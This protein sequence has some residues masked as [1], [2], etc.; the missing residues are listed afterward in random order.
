[1]N[2]RIKLGV[3]AAS[4]AALALSACGSSSLSG[5]PEGGTAPSV[6]VSQNVDLASKLPE[7]IKS[8]GV[9]KIGTDP[10]YAPSEFLAADGKTVEGF[11]V[12]LFNQVAAKFGVKTEWEPSKFGSIIT[13]VNGKKYDMGISS[14]TINPDRLKEVD[15]VSYFNA[16]TQWATQQGNPKG[17]DPNNACGKN[18]AVQTGTVQENPD[19]STR[20]KKCGSNK[21]NVLSYDSQAQ[22]TSAVVTGK[23]DAMLADSPV[24]AYAVK[25]SGGKLEAL[26]DI[27]EAA[28][29]GYVL[30]KGETEFAQAIVEALKQLEQEG[31]YKAALE[32]WGV[33]QGAISDFAVNP[34]S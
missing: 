6:S 18:I 2:V 34:A 28:P 5:E 32:K 4:V 8:A 3:A 29:Y 10:T 26:G 27:Y 25:Q 15:M 17:I 13:G 11:D 30:P 31:A 7:S 14:F 20:Q 16:G 23:A 33:E 9:I 1:M 21:I 22:A 19:L 24:V 12:D